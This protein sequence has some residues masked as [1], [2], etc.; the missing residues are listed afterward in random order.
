MGPK[1]ERLRVTVLRI[2]QSILGLVRLKRGVVSLTELVLLVL[3][4]TS[5]RAHQQVVGGTGDVQVECGQL[6]VKP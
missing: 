2:A 5:R 4:R 3:C 6:W 1:A